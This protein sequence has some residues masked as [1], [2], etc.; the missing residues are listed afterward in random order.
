MGQRNLAIVQCFGKEA[1]KIARE[2]I[3]G[4][5]WESIQEEVSHIMPQGLTTYVISADEFDA[6]HPG[7]VLP[8]YS[9]RVTNG[10]STLVATTSAYDLQ[11]VERVYREYQ[12]MKELIDKNKDIMGKIK[13]A[14]LE[15]LSIREQIIEANK[16]AANLYLKGE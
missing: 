4:G 15:L 10:I 2:R 14:E 13:K 12:S 6:N 5:R 1:E 11:D 7:E 9:L 3:E 8:C 16:K